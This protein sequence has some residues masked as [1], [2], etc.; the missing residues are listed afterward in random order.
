Q[1][2]RIELGKA[3]FNEPLHEQECYK[4]R[5]LTH[6]T[7]QG[8]EN[9]RRSR[10]PTP[11]ARPD[12]TDHAAAHVRE[13][14]EPWAPTYFRGCG[15]SPARHAESPSAIRAPLRSASPPCAVRA[16]LRWHRALLRRRDDSRAEA[17]AAGPP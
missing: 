7:P 10:D 2:P 14:K 12:R 13:R 6:R 4:P 17:R 9:S 11:K 8:P 16:P 5:A 3:E 15:E 1:S